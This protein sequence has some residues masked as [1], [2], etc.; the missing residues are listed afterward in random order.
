MDQ[1]RTGNVA[2]E[3]LTSILTGGGRYHA[4]DMQR[5]MTSVGIDPHILG[6]LDAGRICNG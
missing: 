3:M 2:S 1:L 5:F 4:G 6:I